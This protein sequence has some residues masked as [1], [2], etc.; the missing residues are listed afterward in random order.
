MPVTLRR[1][2]GFTLIELLIGLAIAAILLVMA[3][4]M[5]VNWI[6]DSQTGNA[7]S[8]LADGLR[9]AQ[10][11]AIRRNAN[12]EFTFSSTGWTIQQPSGA[13]IRVAKFPEGSKYTVMTPVPI[14]STTVTFNAFGQV[15]AANAAAPTAPFTE[16]NVST[17]G[18]ARDLRVMVGGSPGTTYGIRV[19]DPALPST[20]PR[21]C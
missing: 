5:Y 12:V 6:S 15:A 13:A 3:V 7:A 9:S 14:G 20:D 17:A 21:G 10:G 1:H 16:I 8:T 19:C 4:P 11:E 2:P 18:S